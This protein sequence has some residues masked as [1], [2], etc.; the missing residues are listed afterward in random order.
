MFQDV[1]KNRHR[2]GVDQPSGVPQDPKGGVDGSGKKVSYPA[3]LFPTVTL[4][5]SFRKDPIACPPWTDPRRA[6]NCVETRN[7]SLR[8][9]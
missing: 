7:C 6:T 3:R 5:T 9:I 8:A 4:A 2:L 1:R